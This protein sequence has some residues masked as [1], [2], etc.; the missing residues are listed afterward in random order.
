MLPRKPT[1]SCG[2]PDVRATMLHDARRPSPTVSATML[3]LAAL[4]YGTL[5]WGAPELRRWV[6]AAAGHPPY[7]G[8]WGLFEHLFLYTTLTAAVCAVA[9]CGFAR[10]GWM[11]GP[12]SV[13]GISP[14]RR[15]LAWGV[16]IGAAVFAVTV[17]GMLLL[18]RAGVVP[19]PALRFHP[20]SGWVLAGDVFS[21]FYEE[22]I[23]RGFLF[24]VLA[25]ISG[26][27]WIAVAATSVLFAASHVQYPFAVR[28]LIAVSAAIACV[29]RVR[30]GSVMPV[31]IAHLLSN[32]LADSWL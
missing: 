17:A 7:A 11:A 25:R 13:L 3:L 16:A 24:A 15:V 1:A 32:A 31:W 21:S 5:F 30:T 9:W 12:M 14:L 26:R 6:Q 2:S 22:F 8:P 29:P 4:A 20:P 18:H 27:A 23:Y 19:D 10:A 28:A